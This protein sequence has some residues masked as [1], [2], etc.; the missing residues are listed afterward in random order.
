ML[1]SALS[2]TLAQ[3]TTHN[4]ATRICSATSA[5]LIVYSQGQLFYNANG[6]AAGYGTGGAFAT[7][8]NPAPTLSVNDFIISGAVGNAQ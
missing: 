2:L 1:K 6:A 5:G 7:F 3:C 8:D 4:F